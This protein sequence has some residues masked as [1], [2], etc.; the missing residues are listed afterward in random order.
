MWKPQPHWLVANWLRFMEPARV[1][2]SPSAQRRGPA[3]PG[4]DTLP[5]PDQNS[6]HIYSTP[7]NPAT[8]REIPRVD[9][10]PP[11]VGTQ[12]HWLV[13]D[14]LRLMEPAR[15]ESSPSGQRRGLAAPGEDKLPSPDQ[16]Y[17]HVSTTAANRGRKRR[18][19]G[20]LP[21]RTVWNPNR[22]WLVANCR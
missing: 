14:W 13:A 11:G 19:P 8:K 1:E 21:L 5:S 18:S 3:A 9:P 12:P 22:I 6:F 17:F 20:S 7:N 4:E 15:G 10:A 16:K 2:S